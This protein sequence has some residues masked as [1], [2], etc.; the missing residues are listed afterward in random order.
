[1]HTQSLCRVQ[2]FSTPW[3]IAYQASLSI[4]LSMKGYWSGLPFPTPNTMEYYLALKKKEI[5]TQATT[6]MNPKDIML[7]EEIS[8]MEK[9]MKYKTEKYDF[10]YTRCP[11]E[12]NSERQES[13]LVVARRWGKRHG[14]NPP[15][16]WGESL[17]RKLQ[18]FWR[19][20][21]VTAARRCEQ[22]QCH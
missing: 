15:V 9:D 22:T 7:S 21:V 14:A 11:E 8:Q 20:M 18:L 17:F 2:L 6:G 4:E 16:Q 13:K 10:T 19:W 12:S 3:T 5:L 1:M